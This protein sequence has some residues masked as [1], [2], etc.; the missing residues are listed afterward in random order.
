MKQDGIKRT[1]GLADFFFL[2]F[3]LLLLVYNLSV[4]K[5]FWALT[6]LFF[7][8]T[9]HWT[10]DALSLIP[11]VLWPFPPPDQANCFPFANPSPSSRCK[12]VKKKGGQST[13]VIDTH[14]RVGTRFENSG[15][16]SIP[17]FSHWT[18]TGVSFPLSVR[19]AIGRFTL[20]AQRKLTRIPC[21]KKKK[22]RKWL[23]VRFFW[24][25]NNLS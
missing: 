19:L 20:L 16:S 3:F 5:T 18:S 13:T 9:W 17:L 2:L 1:K 4:K 25:K 6:T 23:P 15:L 22:K 11:I 14:L 21:E 24:M 8:N 7:L 10:V 12:G